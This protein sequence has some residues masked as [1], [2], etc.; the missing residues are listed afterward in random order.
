MAKNICYVEF[1]GENFP[2]VEIT[3]N[4]DKGGKLQVV[5]R[6]IHQKVHLTLH[7]QNSGVLLAMSDTEYI[8]TQ[9]KTKIQIAKNSGYE[10]PEKH[11]N[12]LFHRLVS[13]EKDCLG[14]RQVILKKKGSDSKYLKQAK[15]I[16]NSL[17]DSPILEITLYGVN[18]TQKPNGG[19]IESGFG[20]LHFK[21]IDK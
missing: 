19:F 14:R 6:Y 18:H 2:V 17:V 5:I 1:R 13:R 16:S 9:S 10:K 11:G 8:S 4:L 20:E 3:E 7:E 21:I 12:Y 15:L